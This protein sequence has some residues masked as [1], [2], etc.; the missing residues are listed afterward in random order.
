MGRPGLRW[1]ADLPGYE[2]AVV[3]DDGEGFC[4]AGLPTVSITELAHARPA[5]P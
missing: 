4:S 3:T 1:L 5:R 2:A